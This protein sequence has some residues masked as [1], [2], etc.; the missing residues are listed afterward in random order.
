MDAALHNMMR[1]AIAGGKAHSIAEAA[2]QVSH[3]APGGG[4][5]DS[6]VQRLVRNYPY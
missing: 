5:A 3:L 6:K 4:S 1:L 2:R